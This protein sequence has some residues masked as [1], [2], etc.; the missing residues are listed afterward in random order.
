MGVGQWGGGDSV[1]RW[2]GQRGGVNSVRG[3]EWDISSSESRLVTLSSSPPPSS[4]DCAANL[5]PMDTNG[6][7]DPYVKLRLLPESS[8]APKQKTE[9][10]EKTLD[11]EWDE[12]FF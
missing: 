6:L 8:S 4:V 12:T 1:R 9:R 10:K 7:A 2:E 5:P 11:P 3:L